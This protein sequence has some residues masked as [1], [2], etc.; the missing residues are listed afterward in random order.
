MPSSKGYVR[1]L[2]REYATQ[3]ARGESGTGSDSENA[4]RHRDRRTALKLGIIKKSQDNDHKAPL[5]KGGSDKP[6]NLRGETPHQNR[7]FPR[8]ADGS[9]IK[10][11]EKTKEK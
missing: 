8:R 9:M 5:S 11:V 7:S 2:K 10:N 4:K 6:S 3:K 1:N